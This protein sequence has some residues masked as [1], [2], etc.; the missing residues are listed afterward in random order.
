[1]IQRGGAGSILPMSSAVISLFKI[2][3]L[4]F[5]GRRVGSRV[6]ESLSVIWFSIWK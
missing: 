4:G 2:Y 6:A 1:M 5:S 3:R